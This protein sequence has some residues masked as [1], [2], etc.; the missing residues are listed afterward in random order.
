MHSGTARLVAVLT[1][2]ADFGAH[3][4]M[5]GLLVSQQVALWPG[6]S[7]TFN[8]AFYTCAGSVCEDPSP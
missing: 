5:S 7:A 3:R 2:I 4:Y 1:Q 8:V 6:Q